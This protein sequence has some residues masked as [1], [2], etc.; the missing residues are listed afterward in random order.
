MV[1]VPSIVTPAL[2]RASF[3]EFCDEDSYPDPQIQFWLNDAQQMMSERWGSPGTQSNWSGLDTGTALYACHYL[4]LAARNR[5]AAEAGGIPGDL[6]GPVSSKS[7]DKV[8]SSHDTRAVTFEGQAFWNQTQYGVMY[9]NRAKNFGAGGI[10]IGAVRVPQPSVP[11][12]DIFWG[13]FLG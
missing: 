11:G 8:S 10:Q 7:V 12:Q 13:Q 5:R 6:R 9:W 1:P 2:L 4:S 3:P